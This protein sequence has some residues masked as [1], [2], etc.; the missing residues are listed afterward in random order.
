MPPN[1]HAPHIESTV[2]E[3]KRF[4]YKRHDPEDVQRY[5]LRTGTQAVPRVMTHR[6]AAEE[7]RKY[8]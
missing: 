1:L 4:S 2:Q 3:Q 5:N 7:H 6:N 8:T